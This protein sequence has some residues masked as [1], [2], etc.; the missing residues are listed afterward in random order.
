[1]KNT[2]LIISAALLLST[3]GA[4]AQSGD[5]LTTLNA[6]HSTGKMPDIPLIPQNGPKADSIR[7][8]LTAIKLPPGFHI[9]LY[10][11]VPD[12]RHI[13]VGPQGIATFVTTRKTKVYT[14]TDRG[15][16]GTA[17]EVKQFAPTLGDLTIPDGACFSKDGFLYLTQQNMVIEFP[18]AEFFY[19]SPDVVPN[20]IVAKGDLIPKDVESYCQASLTLR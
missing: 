13:A 15:K 7:R 8:N 19:E 18:A 3:A 6:M 2:S 5:A 20:P 4:F 16:T 10:A 1:M 12:A 14:V 17:D 9:A 11:L